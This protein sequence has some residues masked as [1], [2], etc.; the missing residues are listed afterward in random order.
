MRVAAIPDRRFIDPR[1]YEKDRITF[2]AI[3][4]KSR[5]GP[6]AVPLTAH[7]ARILL[8]NSGSKQLDCGGSSEVQ[9]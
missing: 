9:A 2:M 7:S 8:V 3:F 6:C 5:A 4:P 1:D